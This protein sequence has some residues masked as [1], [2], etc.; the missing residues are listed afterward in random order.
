MKSV[1]TLDH[2]RLEV[3]TGEMKAAPATTLGLP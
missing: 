1:T 2:A 3:L